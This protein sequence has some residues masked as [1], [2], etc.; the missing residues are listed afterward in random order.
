[1]YKKVNFFGHLTLGI[2]CQQPGKWT[3][4]KK[5]PAALETDLMLFHIEFSIAN[6]LAK[7]LDSRVYRQVFEVSRFSLFA[8]C[9]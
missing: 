2:V 6:S 3:I 7:R 1:M 4:T 9:Q 8:N 5:T